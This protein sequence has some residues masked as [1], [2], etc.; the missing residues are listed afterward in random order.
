MKQAHFVVAVDDAGQR[1]DVFLGQRFADLSRSRITSLIRR[2]DAW[3]DG[4]VRKPSF[5][6]RGSE[7]ILL[8]LPQPTLMDLKPE[9]IP[10]EVIH[11]DDLL[12]VLNK[13]RGLV[14]HMGAGNRTGTLVNALLALDIPLSDVGGGRRPGIVH[15]LDKGTSGVLIVAKENA[16]HLELKCQ[17]AERKVEKRYRAIICGVPDDDEFIVES[18][19]DR[20]PV[21]RKR[22]AVVKH[23]GRAARTEFSVLERFKEFA[24]VDA[25]MRTGRTHQIRVH[26]AH[27]GFPVVGDG[28]YGGREAASTRADRLGDDEVLTLINGLGGHALHAWRIAFRHPGSL[29]KVAFETLLPDDMS[30]IVERLRSVSSSE[31]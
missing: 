28:L 21:N 29:D 31:V 8:Q 25:I 9:P 12:L 7:H 26:L 15:R 3:V 1:L 4:V 17:F 6:L 30:Q 22:M 24:M 5:I 23:G 13:P 20:H 27:S 10:L 19:L 14:V 11:Q 18:P 2:G 16:A